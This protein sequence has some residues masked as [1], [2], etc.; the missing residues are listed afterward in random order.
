MKQQSG[1]MHRLPKTYKILDVSDNKA[2]PITNLPIELNSA[3]YRSSS[4]SLGHLMT[5][6]TLATMALRTCSVHLKKVSSDTPNRFDS[7]IQFNHIF[8]TNVTHISTGRL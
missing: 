1:K 4:F 8:D 3:A 7:L 5:S 6:G 2:P